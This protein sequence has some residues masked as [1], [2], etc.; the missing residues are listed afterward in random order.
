MQATLLVA[1]PNFDLTFE[2]H[3][4]ACDIDIA[5]ALTQARQ[6]LAYLL[7]VLDLMNKGGSTNG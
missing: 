2:V 6:P 5:A 4:D 1:M 7:R 3:Y